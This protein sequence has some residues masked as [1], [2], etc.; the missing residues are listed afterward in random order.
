MSTTRAPE[1]IETINV[2]SPV[3]DRLTP[4]KKFLRSPKIE[5]GS[6]FSNLSAFTQPLE[7][8]CDLLQ[9]SS[10][11]EKPG[12]QAQSAATAQGVL[13]GLDRIDNRLAFNASCGV[14]AHFYSHPLGLQCD[15]V[16]IGVAPIT[17]YN[18]LQF[19]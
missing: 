3:A 10:V 13:C 7:A 1:L 19:G 18:P 8:G 15:W 16:V 4:F 12:H 6:S 14:L 11:S 5:N 17:Y 9:P 2:F